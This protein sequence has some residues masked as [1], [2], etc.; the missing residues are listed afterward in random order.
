VY[1]IFWKDEEHRKFSTQNNLFNLPDEGLREIG[2]K[3]EGC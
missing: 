1:I 2:I 3:E